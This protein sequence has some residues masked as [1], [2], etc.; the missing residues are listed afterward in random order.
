MEPSLYDLEK[1]LNQE[2]EK[3][4]KS[5][6]NREHK[7]RM[8]NFKK[9]KTVKIQSVPSNHQSILNEIDNLFSNFKNNNNETV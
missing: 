1:F 8:N 5:V 2:Q 9:T 4:V 3:R 7:K 6:Y